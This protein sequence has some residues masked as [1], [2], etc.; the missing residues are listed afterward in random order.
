MSDAKV[1]I[2]LAELHRKVGTLPLSFIQAD[3]E[4]KVSLDLRRSTVRDVLDAIVAKAP[5]Y[6]YGIVAG[7]LMFYPRDPKWEMQINDLR[8]GPATRVRMA[9]AL[10][11][12]LSRRFPAFANLGGPWILGDPRSYTYQDV[13]AVKGPGSVLD[14]LAQ[15]LGSRPSTYLLVVKEDGWL[16]ASLST[17][18]RDLLRSLKVTAPKT[19]LQRRGETAQLKL[20]GTLDYDGSAKDL[21]AGV[22]GTVYTS[23]DDRVL[24]VSPDGLVTAQ[25]SGK[26]EVKASN[27]H[28]SDWVTFDC[29][30][31]GK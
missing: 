26:A 25:G 31:E 20:I 11:A 8:L 9:E 4:A 13:V 23:S 28:Y 5:V 3:P 30:L 15:L 17:A 22:C 14:L 7:R 2:A 24:T 1:E 10:A 19:T 18:S 6:R 16:G 29:H 12:E 21:T 27:E